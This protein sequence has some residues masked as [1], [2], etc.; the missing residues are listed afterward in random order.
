MI[1]VPNTQ[2]LGQMC[3][4]NFIYDPIGNPMETFKS[5]FS[6]QD[7]QAHL[8]KLKQWKHTMLTYNYLEISTLHHPV[9]D[10]K[11]MCNLLNAAWLLIQSPLPEKS[12]DGL[13]T[14]EQE[15]FLNREC[16][17]ADFYAK[18]LSTIELIDPYLGIQNFYECF[19]LQESHQQLYEWLNTVLSPNVM[20]DEEMVLL[21]YRNFRRL[22]ECCWLIFKRHETMDLERKDLPTEESIAAPIEAEL[23]EIIQPAVL[24][25]FKQFLNVVPAQRLNRGLR[26][27]LVDYLFYNINGLPTDFE[28]TLADFY[29]LTDLLDEIQGKTLD[30]KFM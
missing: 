27:M 26:K 1:N 16:L 23:N 30:P 15:I 4:D 29:W 20:L 17:K 28:E 22:M 14:K 6:Y 24:S 13:S 9:Y 10:H 21:F 8:K 3:L 5:F 2:L 18:H 12:L 11:M 7:L 19:T 25:T